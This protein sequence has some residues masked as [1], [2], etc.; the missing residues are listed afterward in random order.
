MYQVEENQW[1]CQKTGKK[2][3]NESQQF[4]QTSITYI[5]AL[6]TKYRLKMQLRLSF[7]HSNPS[8]QLESS[9]IIFKVLV[10]LLEFN[11]NFLRFGQPSTVIRGKKN[12]K[13]HLWILF[14]F[15]IS[16]NCNATSLEN[17]QRF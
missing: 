5:I 15:G 8:H 4:L 17:M 10:A 1:V 2:G 14:R 13:T 6:D 16:G 3:N 9:L 12:G 11:G 7:S